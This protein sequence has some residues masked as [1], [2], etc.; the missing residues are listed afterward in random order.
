VP[1]EPLRL[2]LGGKLDPVHGRPL[3]V[4][5][6]LETFLDGPNPQA[7]LR[8]GNVH[9]IVTGKR[10]PYHR[11]DDFLALGLDPLRHPM[12]VVKIGYL[13]PELAAMARRHYLVLSPGGVH[14]R[15]ESLPYTRLRRPVFPL[16]RGFPWE[17]KARV[18]GNPVNRRPAG[19]SS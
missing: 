5:G 12:T 11:R 17:P 3:P 1:G 2:D 4:A 16:D 19:G 6:V 10:R 18:F 8:C 9:V 13:E 14:P 7:V 15:L